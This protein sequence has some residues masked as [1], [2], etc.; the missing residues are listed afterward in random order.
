MLH[1]D[2]P[3]FLFRDIWLG[4]VFNGINLWNAS[5]VHFA[6]GGLGTTMPL[7][8]WILLRG[9]E[10]Q[11]I[12]RHLVQTYHVNADVADVCKERFEDSGGYARHIVA[13]VIAFAKALILL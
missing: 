4:V 13:F 11:S 5:C 1:P 7:G 12:V 8:L 3:T 10:K 9:S 2:R 6:V